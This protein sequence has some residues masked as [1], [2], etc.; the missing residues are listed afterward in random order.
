MSAIFR[1]SASR[2]AGLVHLALLPILYELREIASEGM[3]L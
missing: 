3:M 2:I 1:S